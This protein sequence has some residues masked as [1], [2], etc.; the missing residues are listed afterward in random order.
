MLILWLKIAYSF[1]LINITGGIFAVLTRIFFDMFTYA[2]FYFA[3][4]FLF[5]VVGV[6]LFNDLPEF[7]TLQ[8]TLFTM[9]KAT[10]QE[11][12]IDKM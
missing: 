2:V 9:F 7:N 1:K 10:I 8:S 6:V 4:L 5:S 3:V 11:Y 12:D